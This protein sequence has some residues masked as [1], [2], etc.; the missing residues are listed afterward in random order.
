[1]MITAGATYILVRTKKAGRKIELL[2][3]IVNPTH[4]RCGDWVYACAEPGKR[5]REGVVSVKRL[6]QAWEIMLCPHRTT[7]DVC[8]D[9]CGDACPFCQTIVCHCPKE[10]EQ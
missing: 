1:M 6:Q 4:P 7:P 5:R 8:T 9:G 10:K 2:R 3:R